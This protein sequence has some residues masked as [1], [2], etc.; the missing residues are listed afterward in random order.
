MR[1]TR[2]HKVDVAVAQALQFAD[3]HLLPESVLRVEVGR[4]VIPRASETELTAAIRF[5]DDSKRLT[6]VTGDTEQQYKLNDAGKAWLA[7]RG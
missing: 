1:S 6:S 7:E 5:H 2:Q 4:L 3:P